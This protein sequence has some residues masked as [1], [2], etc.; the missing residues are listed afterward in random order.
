MKHSDCYFFCN[1]YYLARFQPCPQIIVRHFPCTAQL[2]PPS[3]S[4]SQKWHKICLQRIFY[5][6]SA[7][8]FGL[9][10]TALP[11][12]CLGPDVSC[13]WNKCFILI[14]FPKSLHILFKFYHFKCI[15]MIFN[16]NIPPFHLILWVGLDGTE[17]CEP[18][19]NRV[20]RRLPLDL[21][22]VNKQTISNRPGVA[23]AVLQTPS[24]V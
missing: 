12:I 11:Y 17:F 3:R 1:P 9:F 14:V 24:F 13:H 8:L 16:L 2:I 21:D 7:C 15:F 23:W 10:A 18:A 20:F 4:R 22:Y 5:Y 6:C 19:L